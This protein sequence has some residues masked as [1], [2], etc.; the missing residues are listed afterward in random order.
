MA[1]NNFSV[2]EAEGWKALPANCFTFTQ[3][4][5]GVAFYA[6]PPLAEEIPVD[7]VG[8]EIMKTAP[9]KFEP[10]KSYHISVVGS[11]AEFAIEV[12]E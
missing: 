1:T 4:E 12:E 9:Y 6:E 5:G 2:T 10:T 11:E 3:N 8:A 7:V